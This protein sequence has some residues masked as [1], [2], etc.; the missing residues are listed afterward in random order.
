MRIAVNLSARQFR[1]QG[2]AVLV[3]RVL[4]D[5]RLEP[6]WLELEI[7]ESMLMDDTNYT[8]SILE[9]LHG[10]GIHLSIDDFGTG[11]SSL[12]YLKRMP[13]HSLK[14]DRSF[15]QDITTDNNDAAVVQTI[16]AMAHILN[17]RVV[18]EG[19]ET[20]EQ[21]AFL[22]EQN[23]DETQG[24]YFS[25]PLPAD[26]LYDMLQHGFKLNDSADCK[27]DNTIILHPRHR[28]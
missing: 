25:R 21:V 26:E 27:A 18:A 5:T 11:Y 19:T 10:M 3:N 2:L 4:T 15:V 6:Q 14:I 1:D 7:T 17:L 22:R 23:C 20:A 9:Q 24:F 28:A 8:L 16:I 13:I 12:A